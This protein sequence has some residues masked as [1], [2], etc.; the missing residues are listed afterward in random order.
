MG[1]TN[2]RVVD[3]EH[4][5]VYERLEESGKLNMELAKA[6]ILIKGFSVTSEELESYF[7][8]LTGGATHA[9]RG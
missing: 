7:F 1:F 5:Q 2:Y 6:G 3:S 9:E 4:I 8:N